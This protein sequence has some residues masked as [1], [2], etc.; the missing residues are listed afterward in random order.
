MTT[1]LIPVTPTEG[2]NFNLTY[3][4][5]NQAAAISATNSPENPG[6]PIGVGTVV[7]GLG[8][9]EFVFVQAAATINLGDCC[10]I[11]SAT[12]VATPLTT[13]LA[14]TNESYQLGFAQVPIASGAYG[15]LQ[16]DGACQNISVAAAC[17][18]FQPLFA[19]AVA[20]VLD[21]AG[22]VSIAGVTI[23]TTVV[24]AAATPGTINRPWLPI[25]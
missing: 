12:Q 15:W 16:R 20:G 1:T 21:D 3:T 25:T 18:Q 6:P 10:I 14:A 11:A 7:K 8:D 13:A 19:T 5:Y 4:A 23:T 22:T 9:S 2:V 17:V 24:G